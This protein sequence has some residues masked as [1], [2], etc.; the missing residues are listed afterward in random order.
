MT[1]LLVPVAALLTLAIPAPSRGEE[2]DWT[3]YLKGLMAD[4]ACIE[5]GIYSQ[6]GSAWS[7]TPNIKLSA[8]EVRMALNAFRDHKAADQ[9]GVKVAGKKYAVK[10]YPT[11]QMLLARSGDTNLIEYITLRSLILCMI[12]ADAN[13]TPVETTVTN[14]AKDLLSK[15][16]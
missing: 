1:R 3:V 7:T 15:Q 9:D 10:S 2:A 14:V 4:G 8:A 16:L 12:P 13:P 5:A 11:P 6:E